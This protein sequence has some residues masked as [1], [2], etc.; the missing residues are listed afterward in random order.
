MP[1]SVLILQEAQYFFPAFF[2]FQSYPRHDSMDFAST[3]LNPARGTVPFFH[4]RSYPMHGSPDYALITLNPAQGTVHLLC[5]F[6]F[7][8]LPQ[9]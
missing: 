4:Y 8:I 1:E 3:S 9:A 7:L 6:S 5:F 2:H